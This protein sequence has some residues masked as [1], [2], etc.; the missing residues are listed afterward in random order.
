M[1]DKMRWRYGETNPV[2]APVDAAT[3]IDVGDLVYLSSGKAKS[4]STIELDETVAE[5]QAAFT[6]AF[7]GVA[8]QKSVAGSTAPVRVATSGVFEFDA[9]ADTYALGNL[10]GV[11]ESAADAAPDN[12]KVAKVSAT[13]AAVGRI[14][15][16]E[17]TASAVVLVDVHSV[18]MRGALA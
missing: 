2:V 15:R 8:M 16:V 5:T 18:I 14:A 4:A 6:A 13:T 9:S 11:Y 3:T 7:L 1:S 17:S 10:V 12:Q